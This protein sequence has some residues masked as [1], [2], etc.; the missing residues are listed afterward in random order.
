L[1]TFEDGFADTSGQPDHDLPVTTVEVRLRAR[2][3]T[4]TM[5]M[6]LRFASI[7]DME[8]II[9]TGTDE[10]MAL[11]VRQIDVILAAPTLPPAT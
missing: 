5:T 3:A 8:R 4:T 11:A 1:L 10:G 7:A 6:V 9:E 2:G